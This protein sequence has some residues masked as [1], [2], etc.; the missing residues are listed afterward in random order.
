VVVKYFATLINKNVGIFFN[1]DSKARICDRKI[2]FKVSKKKF[3]KR[4]NFK[5]SK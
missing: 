1:S 2:D 3:S 5:S 4:V